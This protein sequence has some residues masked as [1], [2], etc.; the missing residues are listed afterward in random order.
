M[1]TPSDEAAINRL[2][3]EADE[4]LRSRDIGFEL[5]NMNLENDRESYKALIVGLSLQIET[6]LSL[7][8]KGEQPTEQDI[9]K[10]RDSM[11]FEI[12][13]M[14]L[15]TISLTVRITDEE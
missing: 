4:H 14:I 2:A 12:F 9:N 8:R 5:W 1:K 11:Q 7:L 15:A 13:S 6:L 10:W 3:K